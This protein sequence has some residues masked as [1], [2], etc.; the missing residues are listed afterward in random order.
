[1]GAP[2][3]ITLTAETGHINFTPIALAKMS[4]GLFLCSTAHKA[5]IVLLNY[6]LYCAAIELGFKASILSMDNSQ[7]AKAAMRKLGH[8]LAKVH[9]R[10]LDLFPR[11]ELLDS[12]DQVALEKI[13]PYYRKKGLEYVTADVLG[14]LAA[15]L[16]SFP[17]PTEIQVVA[18]KVNT[19]LQQRRF[20]ID[21]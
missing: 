20:F 11:V 8:D 9:Q 18:Q 13:N 5:D 17:S 19:F 6:F 1:M 21:C 2:K 14:E 16:S 15:G 10:F 3:N 4:N 7:A 12:D